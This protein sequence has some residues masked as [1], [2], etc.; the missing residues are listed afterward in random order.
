MSTTR[1]LKTTKNS[2][3]LNTWRDIPSSWSREHSV[4]VSIFPKSIYRFGAVLF[5]IPVH[6]CVETA[7]LILKFTWIYQG[8]RISKIILKKNEIGV[9]TLHGFKT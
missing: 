7:M 5:K 2:G 9:L 4:I 8:P 3:Y 6:F 1:T